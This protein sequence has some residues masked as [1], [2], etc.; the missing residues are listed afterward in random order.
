MRASMQAM[1]LYLISPNCTALT[2]G[3]LDSTVLRQLSCGIRLALSGVPLV[4]ATLQPEW[5][6][7]GCAI[8]W[9]RARESVCACVWVNVQVH[10]CVQ[11]CVRV[12]T[13]VCLHAGD[14]LQL[15]CAKRAI[16]LVF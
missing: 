4:C 7:R 13:Y 8:S 2:S 12:H 16:A 14:Q 9:A 3:E 11:G 1:P 15:T 5:C 10:A 6:V